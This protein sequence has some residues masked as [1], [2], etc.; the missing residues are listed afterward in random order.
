MSAVRGPI[1]LLALTLAS[2]IATLVHAQPAPVDE[3]AVRCAALAGSGRAG[4]VVSVA[5][6]RAAQGEQ[7]AHC[8]VQGE[9]DRRK[10]PVDGQDYA[11]GFHLRVPSERW[12]GRLVYLAQGGNE[13][14][15]G[16]AL[17]AIPSSPESP[18]ALA[19]GFAVVTTD[20]GH[21]EHNS[22]HGDGEQAHFGVDPEARLDYG[23]NADIEVT[24][25][26]KRLIRN[27]SG[28]L[29][30][31]SYVMGCSN[32]GRHAILDA[33][34]FPDQFDGVLAGD[35]GIDLP[36]AAVAEA[37]DDQ[38]LAAIATSKDSK[39]QPALW[40]AFSASDMTLVANAVLEQCDALDGLKDGIIGDVTACQGRFKPD[41][42]ECKGDK[43]PACLGAEQMQAL[44]KMMGGAR[45]GRGESLYSAWP[46]D[47]GLGA[48]GWRLW[49][50]GTGKGNARFAISAG[51][52]DALNATLGAT[53]LPYVFITPPARGADAFGYAL[54]FSFD[55]DAPGIS[56][57][58]AST[59]LSSLEFMAASSD[60]NAFIARG[61]KM[62]VYHGV[63]DPVFSLFKTV[64]W[65]EQVAD[66]NGGAGALR[67]S[68]RLYPV[69]GMNH[70]R[71]GPA[72]SNFDGLAALV[73]WVESGVVP[74]TI[75]ATAPQDASPPVP[76]G[77]TRPLCSYPAVARYQGSGDIEKAENFLCQ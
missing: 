70:C 63:S 23:Y 36:R 55:D 75:T 64:H 21:A 46:W 14:V 47:A 74:E 51:R 69:P 32:G 49:K 44:L 26:A 73:D 9:I 3:A 35:P 34:R 62:I 66:A 31:H 6:L 8:E 43:T 52:N 2:G 15:L 71:G 67:N 57:R 53:S 19:R 12:N 76:P 72:T 39:G 28:A 18:G 40:S 45:N 68:V 58:D 11:I 10:S 37:W 60:I 1:Q 24:R 16:D 20:G 4:V 33:A 56:A 25:L 50:L 22:L 13:G 42:L 54:A 38:A 41:S 59:G 27:F 17:G 30:S 65:Y 77:R 61:G 5:Q 7:P 48:P 29:P